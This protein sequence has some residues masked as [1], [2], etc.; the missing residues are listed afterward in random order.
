MC[1]PC[2][3]PLPQDDLVGRYS[4]KDDEGSAGASGFRGAQSEQG[5]GEAAGGKAGSYAGS[6]A[7]GNAFDGE[8]SFDR[9][10]EVRPSARARLQAR[11]RRGAALHA[12]PD[13]RARP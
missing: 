8:A 5:G 4:T 10:A 3:P 6:D 13:P 1:P 11:L 7:G 9:G 2:V 12:A